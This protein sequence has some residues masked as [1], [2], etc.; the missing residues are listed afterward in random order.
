MGLPRRLGLAL[1][2]PCCADLD[3]MTR[4]GRGEPEELEEDAGPAAIPAAVAVAG[5]AA[6]AEEPDAEVWHTA[7]TAA[8]AGVAPVTA[9]ADCMAMAVSTKGRPLP[10]EEAGELP[11]DMPSK[12]ERAAW[13][14]RAVRTRAA[15]GLAARPAE[16]DVTSALLLP[17]ELPS[18]VRE[19]AVGTVMMPPCAPE[20]G[21]VPCP[22]VAGERGRPGGRLRRLPSDGGVV[23]APGLASGGARM[24]RWPPL[25]RGDPIV[26]EPT[27]A[28]GREGCWKSASPRPAATPGSLVLGM[29]VAERPAEDEMAGA[30]C[31]SDTCLACIGA[32][33]VSE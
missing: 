33:C 24:P 15:D 27:S 19:P 13:A 3:T 30:V 32:G 18:E 31:A 17:V 14:R 2:F 28:P 11:W 21:D 7:D 20:R 8:P 29:W 10:V 4:E 26:M 6:G 22:A 5:V 25:R 16:R 9:G 23:S 1:R 12:P